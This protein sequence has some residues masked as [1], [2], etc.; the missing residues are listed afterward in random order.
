MRILAVLLAVIQFSFAFHAM[1]TGRG[2]MWI[3]II[4]VFPVVGCLAYYF[5]EVFP[6]SREHRAVRK[7]IRD[8]AKAMN[9]DGELQRRTEEVA[10]TASVENRAALADECLEKGM[11]D[12]AIRLYEGCLEGPHAND[13][14]ILFG[15]ARA[16]F[17]NGDHRPAEEIL[18]R[19]ARAHPKFRPDEVRLLQARVLEALGDTQGA[20]AAYE[21]LRN[22]YVGFEAKYRYG[23]LLKRLGRDREADE[24]FAFIG[25][26]ARRSALE[27][28]HEWVKLAA[29]E[30]ERERE[31]ATA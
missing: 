3:T 31:S 7:H 2:A 10:T 14:R 18:A 17:Y 25:S 13:P 11:F 29:R 16:R 9:P 4:I 1:K 6:Q 19:L 8:I 30:R 5:M 24:L 15:C 26:H 21:E 28:E 27:S 12:E 22:R 23:V 20:L